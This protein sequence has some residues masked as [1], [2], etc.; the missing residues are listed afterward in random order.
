[1][2]TPISWIKA[3]VPDLDCSV[4]EYVDK[5]TLSGSHVENAVYLDKNLEKIVVGRIEKIERHPDADKLVVCQVNVGES[6]NIQIVTGAP[7]VF[8]GALVPV[9]LDGGRV[10]GGHDGSPNPEGGIKIKK[11]KLRGV[12]SMGMMCS[13]EE[14]GSDRN[15]YPEAPEDGIYIF[16][17][18]KGVKPG[19]DA[20]EA[21]GLHDAVVEFEIT[22]NRVDCFSMVGMAR[23][24]AA[25]FEKPFFPPVVTES[26][27][28]E[29]VNDY[30]A[31]E[32]LDTEL[33]PRYTA[34]VVKNIKIGPS[35]EWMQ[36]RL[37][38]CG[39]RPINNIVDI[40][41]YVMEEFGQPM[42]AYD[43]ETIR[44]KKIIVK[45]ANDGDK[46]TTL[47]GQERNLDHDVLMINDAEGPVGV[48]GIMGGENSMVT[49]DIKTM[50]FE[51]ATFDGTNI[52]LS[53]KRI[54][55]RT[56]AS[57]KFEKGLDPE[58]ALAAINC[59]C[60]LVEELGAGEVVGGVVD[61]YPNPVEDIELPFEAEKYNKL[62]GTEISDE[63]MLAYFARLDIAYN[64]ETNMLQ[65]PSFR[66]DLRCSADIAEEVARF[67]GYDNIPTTLPHGEATAGKRSFASRVEGITRDVVEQNG[68]CGGMC[69]SFE[70]P[71]V[72]DKLLIPADDELRQAIVIS[73]PLGEDY[74]IMRTI[75]LNGILTS[76]ASNY[77]HRNKNVRLYEI[78]NVYLPKSLPLTELPE[79]RKKLTLGM[80]GDCDFFLLKGVLEELFLKLGIAGKV[81][82]EPTSERPFLHP[83]RQAAVYVNG[84]YAGFLGQVHPEVSEN[85]DMKCE[86]YVAG[87]D[88]PVIVENATFDRKYEG[89]AKYPAVNRDLSLVMKKDIFVGQLEKVMR[90]KGGK[91]LESI[92]IFDVYEGSQIEEG[93]KSV[94][95]NLVFRAADRSLEAA[96]VNKVVDKILKE[97][98]KL[99]VELRA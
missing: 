26:G 4:Q 20:V 71:K 89:V 85:Y 72:F 88:L 25:T 84:T 46:Y 90:D 17:Q 95:Y 53:S 66:Q 60:Q 6:E 5:M 48:A 16:D 2:V 56:D 54:G 93:Y 82:Y 12:P 9:V 80:Y 30:I 63:D 10:A 49:D 91:I 81:S 61:V 14:L 67:F 73:N 78:A 74:S 40:T 41:N 68:F 52:R 13:I 31:V 44:G 24:A 43:L 15:F 1:M 57:G 86:A 45:R 35:P 77:N 99:G 51:A 79:E 21:L 62:L 28:D 69:Y 42:H 11:G 36:R 98:T 64:E 34:R 23:E 92:T 83:G 22:S 33:C 65:I 7:N 39:I 19:D 3:Y 50:L 8:E 32:V 29:D 94:A 76:L 75:E 59:A 55:L 47:D 96:E 37:A 38:A 58:N 27:N 18:A 97:L 87:I 70:S